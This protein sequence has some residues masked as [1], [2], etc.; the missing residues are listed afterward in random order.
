MFQ[1]RFWTA[2][3][4]LRP[5]KFSDNLHPGHRPPRSFFAR[6]A[7]TSPPP[8]QEGEDGHKLQPGFRLVSVLLLGGGSYGYTLYINGWTNA[9]G[10]GSRLRSH[11]NMSAFKTLT[12][13]VCLPSHPVRVQTL[14]IAVSNMFPYRESPTSRHCRMSEV[15]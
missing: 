4:I 14:F 15:I 3:S 13:F 1:R 11:Q 9:T 5:I 6:F 12:I 7:S 8:E 2:R 10:G